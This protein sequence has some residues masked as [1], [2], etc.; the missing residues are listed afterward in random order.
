MTYLCV[1]IKRVLNKG[2]YVRTRDVFKGI[3]R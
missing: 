1:F 2:H 3:S